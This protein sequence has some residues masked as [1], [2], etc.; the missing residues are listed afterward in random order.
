M[1]NKNKKSKGFSV[2]IATVVI[3][4]VGLVISSVITLIVVNNLKVSRD[5][6]FAIRSYYSSEGAIED[7]LIRLKN[8]LPYSSSYSLDISTGSVDVSIENDPLY[9]D[10]KNIIA[11]ANIADRV[12]KNIASVRAGTEGVSFNY[13]IQSGDGGFELKNNAVVEGTVYTSGSISGQNNNNSEITGDAWAMGDIDTVKVN[14]ETH[15]HGIYD[16]NVINDAYYE[17]NNI[18][19]TSVGGTEY[20]DSDPVPLEDFPDIDLDFWRN[21]A[22]SGGTIFGDYTLSGSVDFGPKKIVG[23]LI[24]DENAVINMQGP[25]YVTGNLTTRNN[26]LINLDSIF[27][28]SGSVILTDG[29]VDIVNNADL[30]GSGEPGS[31]IL[32]IS[33][34]PSQ[35]PANPAINLNN[36]ATGAVFLATDGILKVNQNMSV[37]AL[38]GYKIIVENNGS[39][40]YDTGL[41]GAQ[42]TSGPSGGWQ[43]VKWKEIE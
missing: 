23:N 10:R 41:A 25:I 28:E 19:D 39:V 35:D 9:P 3:L 29:K 18:A 40:I 15:S 13:A 33:I 31:Y 21:T 8:S 12:R 6:A 4:S 36:N 7:G 5:Y 24:V 27:G 2:I 38:T 26:S 34:D 16:S 32:C 22:A 43:I 11:E 14:G 30:Q 17:S 42:F 1:F 20:P 37:R